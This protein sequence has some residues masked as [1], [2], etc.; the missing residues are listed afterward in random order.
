MLLESLIHNLIIGTLG[1]C[2]TR[3]FY[4]QLGKQTPFKGVTDP[5]LCLAQSAAFMVPSTTI[6]SPKVTHVNIPQRTYLPHQ[7][8]YKLLYIGKATIPLEDGAF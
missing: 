8:L 2:P 3:R 1:C 5:Q 6:N 7:A 4:F